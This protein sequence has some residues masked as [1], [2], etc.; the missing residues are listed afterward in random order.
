MNTAVDSNVPLHLPDDAAKTYLQ[1]GNGVSLRAAVEF[2]HLAFVER[3]I[4]G[5]AP[6][7]TQQQPH[8]EGGVWKC[9]SVCTLKL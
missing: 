8:P 3:P 7:C 1:L 5:H 4:L 9:G 6:L 2:A